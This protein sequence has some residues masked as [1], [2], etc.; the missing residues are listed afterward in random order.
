[1]APARWLLEGPLPTAADS[2][3]NKVLAGASVSGTSIR[4]SETRKVGVGDIIIIPSGVPHFFSSLDSDMKYFVVR[5]D[6]D[7]VLPAEYKYSA[8]NKLPPRHG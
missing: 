4:G 8:Q 6:P 1:M 3:V 2:E 7:R 5:V